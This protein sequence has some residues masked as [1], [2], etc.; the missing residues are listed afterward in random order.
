MKLDKKGF[1]LIELLAVIVILLAISVIAI[2]SISSA[3]ERSKAKKLERQKDIIESYA[4]IYYDKHK[5]DYPSKN[6]F[7]IDVSDL[8]LDDDET[9][10]GKFDGSVKYSGGEFVYQDSGC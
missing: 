6:N 1:T 3:I 10:D 2:P 4:E 9:N 8:N 7:C 5:N